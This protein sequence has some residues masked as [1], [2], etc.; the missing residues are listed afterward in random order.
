MSNRLDDELMDAVSTLTA[1]S[2]G[3]V[4]LDASGVAWQKSVSV[5]HPARFDNPRSSTVLAQSWPIT[6]IHEGRLG[7]AAE[8]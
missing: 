1:L 3:S 8:S 6:V 2:T 5:W 7:D 4:V